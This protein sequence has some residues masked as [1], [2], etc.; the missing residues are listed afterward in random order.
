MRGRHTEDFAGVRRGDGEQL[1]GSRPIH[2]ELG[3]LERP[4]TE[5]RE[6]ISNDFSMAARPLTSPKIGL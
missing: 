4:V 1:R 5:G 3:R 6:E 2:D